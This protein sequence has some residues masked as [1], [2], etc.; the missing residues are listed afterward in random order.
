ME[1][2]DLFGS[3][4]GVLLALAGS[5]VGLG[6]LWRFPY[7]VGSNGGA[8]FIILY[9]FFVFIIC[10]PLMFTEFVIGRRS[11]AN[12]FGAFRSLSSDKKSLWSKIGFISVCV[13]SPSCR[14]ILWWV[15]GR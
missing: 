4:L 12:V 2:R 15:V 13:P 5:A 10:L 11:H 7:L 3:R 14:F 9:L 6:N 1:K 8:M